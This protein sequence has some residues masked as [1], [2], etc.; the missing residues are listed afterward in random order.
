MTETEAS[1][2][3]GL[4]SGGKKLHELVLAGRVEGGEIGDHLYVT[5]ASID[6]Y[7]WDVDHGFAGYFQDQA[8]KQYA[9]GSEYVAAGKTL[10]DCWWEDNFKSTEFYGAF[11]DC[12]TMEDEDAMRTLLEDNEL[13]TEEKDK[14]IDELFEEVTKRVMECGSYSYEGKARISERRDQA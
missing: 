1:D 6:H 12:C 13:S 8:L 4:S 11:F 2:Y 5:R 10:G 3:L 7:K 14:R 9:L